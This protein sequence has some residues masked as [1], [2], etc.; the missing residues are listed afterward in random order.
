M[1]DKPAS[2]ISP[3]IAAGLFTA[4]FL[5]GWVAV[6]IAVTLVALPVAFFLDPE[7]LTHLEDPD[8]FTE[9]LMST[10]LLAV[11][12]ASGQLLGV[13][14]I[15]TLLVLI[16]PVARTRVALTQQLAMSK[17][18]ARNL[19]LATLGGV[20]IGHLPGWG[21]EVLTRTLE[22]RGFEVTHHLE[23]LAKSLADTQNLAWPLMAV[24]VILGAPL[25]EE[26]AFRGALWDRTSRFKSHG[27]LIAWL[28]TSAL[29]ALY[30]ADPLH[31]LGVIPI[32]MYL[33]ALRWRTGDVWCCIAAH[34]A[35]N[36]LAVLMT[37]VWGPEVQIPLMAAILAFVLALAT[38]GPLRQSSR[39]A[40]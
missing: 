9:A 34:A 30:H 19:V 3:S 4:T 25:F 23:L 37:V 22:G 13:V 27:S 12:G 2:P 8:H 38:L 16:P 11:S 18:Q 33:G 40:T 6:N 26:L 28:I 5:G 10:E 24:T 32:G 36:G 29:F 15:L 35:N 39:Q 21:L 7:I 1:Q 31:I 20:G 14:L 17:P